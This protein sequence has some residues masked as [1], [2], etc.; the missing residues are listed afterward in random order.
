LTDGPRTRDRRRILVFLAIV[1]VFRVALAARRVAER[2]LER[3][4]PALR[5]RRDRRGV[6]AWLEG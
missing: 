4:V 3:R 5:R 2:R 1:A 6:E